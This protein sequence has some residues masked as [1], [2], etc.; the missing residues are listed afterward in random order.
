MRPNQIEA[1][2][3]RVVD[4]VEKGAPVE[5]SRVELK[6]VWPD[7]KKAARRIAGHANAAH[8]EPILWLIGVDE[9][10]GAVGVDK[11]DLSKW[12]PQVE[13]QF[14]ALAPRCVDLNVP[15]RGVWVVALL[16]ETDRAPFVV[17]NPAANMD[18]EVPW[19][20]GT[21]VRSARRADL[22]RLLEPSEK[23]PDVDLLYACLNVCEAYNT[24]WAC[25]IISPPRG[26]DLVIPVHKCA[27][28]IVGGSP[29]RTDSFSDLRFLEQTKDS[30]MF[31]L[32][33]T[34]VQIEAPRR[35]GVQV[36]FASNSGTAFRGK[37]VTLSLDL[38]P[39]GFQRAVTIRETLIQSKEGEWELT[40]VEWAK[41]DQFFYLP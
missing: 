23:L 17:N 37:D 15:V 20:E 7:P 31:S 3:L 5:D 22:I 6:A 4:A 21:S 14:D 13:S 34:Q 10:T 1:W 30:G 32:E 18:K 9:K 33:R 36:E 40:R 27:A 24:L 11:Q 8:G 41:L 16:M 39:A 25:L 12:W 19:R 28:A 38:T 2:A 35:I 29:E 26:H